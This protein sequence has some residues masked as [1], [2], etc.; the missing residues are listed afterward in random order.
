MD[1]FFMNRE[2]IELC[3]YANEKE[4]ESKFSCTWRKNVSVPS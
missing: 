3:N 1:V 2:E 4:S